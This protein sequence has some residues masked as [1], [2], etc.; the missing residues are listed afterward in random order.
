MN[1]SDFEYNDISLSSLGYIVASSDGGGFTTTPNGAPIAF[2]TTPILKGDT[3]ILAD[4]KYE[5]CL[6]ATFQIIKNPCVYTGSDAYLDIEE[7]S[8]LSRW[9]NRK[10]FYP[11]CFEIDGY[12]NIYFEGTF[13]D[14]NKLEMDGRVVGLELTLVTNRPYGTMKK[15]R[16]K[17]DMQKNVP[18]SFV[19]LSDEIGF[20]YPETHITCRE[21]GTLI[22][23]NGIEDRYTVIS[24][25]A[26]GENIYMSYP[27][28]TTDVE[29]HDIANCFN[30]N[31]FRIANKW[32]E[33]TNNIT[34]SLNCTMVFEYHP[35]RKVGL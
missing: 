8:K 9:L 1:I 22:L 27:V 6:S 11:I 4:T 17:I 12:E 2:T 33:S 16:K 31:F 15:L 13:N 26:S 7:I 10:G 32:N 34:S 35:I 30:Y 14:I 3:H 5:E 28:I 29:S 25:C 21:N 20:I 24:G 23:S 19:D 18:Y